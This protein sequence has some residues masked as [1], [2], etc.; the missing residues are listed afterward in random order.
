MTDLSEDYDGVLVVG[1]PRSGTTLLRRLINAHPDFCSPGETNLFTACGR[2]LSADETSAGLQIGVES[3]LAFAGVPVAEL[4]KRLRNFAFGL[5]HEIA[6]A[7]DA[8]F[9]VEKTAFNAFYLDNIDALCEDRVRYVFLVRHGL[10]VATSINELCEEN[11]MYL[12]ELHAYAARFPY[13]VQAFAHA[14]VELNERILALLKRRP[15]RCVLIRYEDLVASTS[16]T[17]ES[18]FSSLGFTWSDE[19]ETRAFEPGDQI[20]IGD[21]KTYRHTKTH[22]S[23]ISRW[24]AL[25]PFLTNITADVVNPML[26]RLGYDPV[27]SRPDLGPAE[28]R[29][30]YELGLHFQ[31]G[32][33]QS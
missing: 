20:G 12:A 14:W 10:D 21:W 5:M 15:E 28:A 1:A 19:Y 33:R 6:E 9:W 31:S 24:R 11:G 13:P 30:R 22:E 4:R 32:M 7:N 29:R 18:V 16:A 2:F 25:P 8:R 26:V 27:E 23:S 3:G 17:M